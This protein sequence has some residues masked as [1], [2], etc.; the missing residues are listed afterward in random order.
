MAIEKEK[1]VKS[2]LILCEGRDGLRFCIEMLA[3][4][5]SENVAFNNFQA[6]DFGGITELKEYLRLLLLR[7][8]FADVRSITVIRDAEDNAEGAV[9]SILNSF[10]SCCLPRPSGPGQ[11]AESD[12]DNLKT[13]FVLFPNCSAN[14]AAGTLEDLCLAILAD[15]NAPEV[16]ETVD[17]TLSSYTFKRRHKN[18]LHTY[19]SLTDKYVSLKIG[20]AAKAEAFAFSGPALEALKDFLLQMAG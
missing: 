10:S 14:P 19:L 12:V 9:Q 13:G 3:H 1:L 2:H 5:S 6:L 20:E 18:R 15:K 4:F 17:S 11:P 7:P 8:G 16:L